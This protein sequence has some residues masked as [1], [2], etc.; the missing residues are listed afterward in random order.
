MLVTTLYGRVAV[1][2]HVLHRQVAGRLEP[3][4]VGRTDPAPVAGRDHLP[5]CGTSP[6]GSLAR[7][8]DPPAGDRR[9]TGRDP[10]L[11]RRSGR[12]R[13]CRHV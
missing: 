6:G 5:Q 4:P 2:V 7:T 11:W 3:N 9:R 10:S 12:V 13:R 8:G 1:R